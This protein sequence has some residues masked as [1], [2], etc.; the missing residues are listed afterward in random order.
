MDQ[1]QI[2]VAI[3]V[4]ILAI[5]AAIIIFIAKKGRESGSSKLTVLSFMFMISGIIF[6]EDRST[7]Y[8]LIGVGLLFALLDMI[9]K[10]KSNKYN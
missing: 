7:G 1:S 2:Y 3:S 8:G 6:G 4:V 5:V 10:F 9:N